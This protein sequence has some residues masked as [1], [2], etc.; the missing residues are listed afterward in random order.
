MCKR[1]GFSFVGRLD[2]MWNDV[3]FGRIDLVFGYVRKTI[4]SG[5]SRKH[6]FKHFL[7][8][9]SSDFCCLLPPLVRL[10]YFWSILTVTGEVPR[11]CARILRR[12]RSILQCLFTTFRITR[13]PVRWCCPKRNFCIKNTY[14]Q[15][16][17]I[18]LK[19]CLSRRWKNYSST[20]TAVGYPKV[21]HTKYVT[22]P[23]LKSRVHGNEYGSLTDFMRFTEQHFVFE[24]LLRNER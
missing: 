13:L 12:S 8:V 1:L 20:N 23:E 16:I 7:R 9:F 17:V 2:P 11:F 3:C 6:V 22:E 19:K 5:F 14:L 18:V 15:T 21:S 4:L 10:S 24:K